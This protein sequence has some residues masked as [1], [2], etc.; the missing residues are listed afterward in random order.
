MRAEGV[1][2]TRI[3]MV[4]IVQATRASAIERFYTTGEC[5]EQVALYAPQGNGSYA[6]CP[7]YGN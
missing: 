2:S 3:A 4:S 6:L 7:E 5:A 1:R